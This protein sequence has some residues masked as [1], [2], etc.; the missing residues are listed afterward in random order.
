MAWVKIIGNIDWNRQR[1]IVKNK[2]KNWPIKH[3]MDLVNRKQYCYFLFKKKINKQKN[4]TS[5]KRP[6]TTTTTNERTKKKIIYADRL[7]Y[8][9]RSPARFIC[10][11]T[12]IDWKKYRHASILN[13]LKGKFFL[14]FFCVLWKGAWHLIERTTLFD[15]FTI[16]ITLNWTEYWIQQQCWHSLGHIKVQYNVFPSI[17]FL[18]IRVNVNMSLSYSPV[19]IN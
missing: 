1:L 14:P 8:C 5:R 12:P 2:S 15:W 3:L 4:K 18:H 13:W 9:C 10:V 11:W 6:T 19:S 7:W 17:D 16:E